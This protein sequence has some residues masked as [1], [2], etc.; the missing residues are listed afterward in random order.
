[1]DVLEFVGP[2]PLWQLVVKE[3]AAKP[4]WA[5]IDQKARKQF[6][7]KA[8]WNEAANGHTAACLS[9][10]GW[11]TY[12][13]PLWALQS[14]LGKDLDDIIAYIGTRNGHYLKYKLGGRYEIRDNEDTSLNSVLCQK[15]CPVYREWKFS[16]DLIKCCDFQNWSSFFFLSW[17]SDGKNH[18][19]VSCVFV[20]YM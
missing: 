6:S 3:A 18:K 12:L 8:A 10:L 19:K 1:M 7:S 2:R 16:I 14:W 4:R 11:P 13:L 9:H 15:D 17:I 5:S 20:L